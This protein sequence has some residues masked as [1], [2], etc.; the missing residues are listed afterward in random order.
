VKNKRFDNL[1]R[2]SNRPT[3]LVTTTTEWQ[4]QK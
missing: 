1:R 2:C 4:K 3:L